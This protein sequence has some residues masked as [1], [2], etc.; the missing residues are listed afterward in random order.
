[1]TSASEQYATGSNS[2]YASWPKIVSFPPV[3]FRVIRSGK[4]FWRMIR[5]YLIADPETGEL[6]TW[7]TVTERE[8]VHKEH[9]PERD[10]YRPRA[11]GARRS[12]Q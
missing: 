4:A 6:S 5:T 8:M 9:A 12:M 10:V 1:V 7:G 2:I 3:N 11:L